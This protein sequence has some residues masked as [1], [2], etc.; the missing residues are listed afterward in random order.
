MKKLYCE[1]IPKLNFYFDEKECNIK[2]NETIFNGIP[3]PKNIKIKDITYN[4]FNISWEIDNTNNID[5][6]KIK[7]II[8]IRKDN[9]KFNKVYEG[10]NKNSLI[11]N[12]LSY[13]DYEL[14][15]CS[16]YN[17][18]YGPWSE[19]QK[20]KNKEFDSSI[21]KECERKNEFIKKILEFSGYN[22][23]ELI[24]RGSRDGTTSLKFHEKCDNKGPNII[25]FKNEK[26]NIFGGYCPISWKSEGNWQSVPE[27]FIFTLTNIYNIEPTKF[28]RTNDNSGV[29]FNSSNGPWFGCSS[30]IGFQYDYSQSNNC[31]S[32][33]GD[34][35][36]YKDTLGKGKSIFTG[37]ENNNNQY[38]KLKEIE[39]FKLYK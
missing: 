3:N 27:A 34:Y 36:G 16:F 37:D 4:S 38:Y 29:Y 11:E 18:L 5:I 39:A 24:Y 1:F 28:N 33:F 22:R 10:N 6:N 14:R 13:T 20:I 23:M 12:L 32:Y 30:N 8:E 31:Y 25:L 9:E 21:F 17:D 19:I 2:Y 26:G 35:S 15:I 7:Y